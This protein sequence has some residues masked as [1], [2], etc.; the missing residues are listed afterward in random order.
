MLAA[1]CVLAVVAGCSQTDDTPQAGESSAS[2]S[3]S[4]RDSPPRDAGKFFTWQQMHELGP[5]KQRIAKT[6]H[7]WE[8]YKGLGARFADYVDPRWEGI[9]TESFWESQSSVGQTPD[10]TRGPVTTRLLNIEIKG[11]TALASLCIDYRQTEIAPGDS[12][13]W[14]SQE[15]PIAVGGPKLRRSDRSPTGWIRTGYGRA[16]MDVKDCKRSFADK[17]PAVSKTGAPPGFD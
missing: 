4:A 1:M 2:S 13:K 14:V 16:G 15:P 9:S 8:F 11:K 5:Q 3:P 10:E 17:E 7:A 12:K 6:V